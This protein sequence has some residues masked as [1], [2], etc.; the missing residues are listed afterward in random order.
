MDMLP[1]SDISPAVGDWGGIL[2]KAKK[3]SRFFYQNTMP[4]LCLLT[5]FDTTAHP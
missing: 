1:Q 3:K 4:Y 5:Y 2:T